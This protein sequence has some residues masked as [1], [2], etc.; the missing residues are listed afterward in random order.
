MKGFF[1][2][3]GPAAAGGAVATPTTGMAVDRLERVQA[4]RF[5][6]AFV[7]LLGHALH[8]AGEVTLGARSEGMHLPG[9][10]AAHYAAGVDLFFVISGFIMYHVSRSAFGVPGAAGRF[11]LRRAI[12]IVPPYWIFSVAMLG[13]ITLLPAQVNQSG[14]DPLHALLSFL[15]VPWLNPQGEPFPV[16]ILGWTLNF[17]VFFYAVFALG[18]LLPPG[19]GLG[20][21]FGVILG[22]SVAGGALGVEAM[23]WSVWCSPISLEFL[24][25]VAL[26]RAHAQGIRLTATAGISMLGCGLLLLYLGGKQAPAEVYWQARWLYMGLPAAL[27]CASVVLWRDGQATTLLP[28][29]TP[30]L[31]R[32]GGDA[33]YALYLSHPFSLGLTRWVASGNGLVD[34]WSLLVLGLA[35]SLAVAAAFHFGVEKPTTAW[36]RARLGA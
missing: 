2:L 14:I 27:V 32:W 26:A 17:E 19:Q 35:M 30:A 23:P 10:R 1:T 36:L 8:M 21:L 20:L 15:F 13:A 11:L 33:S 4:L 28:T 3:G 7:V 34:G 12:R 18:L 22:A 24:M 16:L 25:G 9:L 5:A 31:L 29:R 6:A